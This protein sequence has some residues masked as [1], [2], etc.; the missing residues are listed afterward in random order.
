MQP[1]CKA[2]RQVYIA[3][4][5][6]Q[7]L[8]EEQAIHR[9]HFY[10]I[11]T[12]TK[13][14]KE[15]ADQESAYKLKSIQFGLPESDTTSASSEA[16]TFAFKP[17]DPSGPGRSLRVR[18][19]FRCSLCNRGFERKSY[20]DEYQRNHDSNLIF[21]ELCSEPNCSKRFTSKNSLKRHVQT[22]SPAFGNFQTQFY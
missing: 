11:S 18:L 22:V 6:S 19:V 7:D 5:S 17:H 9:D 21:M 16:T 3:R 20:R 8:I 15:L 14:L 13:R 12:I 2:S 4:Q 1:I 10:N